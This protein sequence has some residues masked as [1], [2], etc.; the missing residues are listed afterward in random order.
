MHDSTLQVLPPVH[1]RQHGLESACSI[2]S[3]AAL[4]LLVWFPFYLCDS[5]AYSELASTGQCP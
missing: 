4:S 1:L 2:S 3:V 5:L